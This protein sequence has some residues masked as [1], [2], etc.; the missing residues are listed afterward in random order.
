MVMPG[1]L[2]CSMLCTGVCSKVLSPM[3]QG[4]SQGSPCF[5]LQMSSLHPVARQI[6][7]VCCYANCPTRSGAR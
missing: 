5:V 4:E 1:N 7:Q 2:Y 6:P 3:E